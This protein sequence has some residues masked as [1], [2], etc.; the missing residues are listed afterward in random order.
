VLTQVRRYPVKSCRGEDLQMAEVEPWGLA[1]DRRFMLVDDT[2][3]SRPT[4][5]TI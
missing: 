5:R 2:G 3:S 4:I 1:G